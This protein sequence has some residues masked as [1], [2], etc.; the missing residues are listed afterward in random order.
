[1]RTL[2]FVCAASAALVLAAAGSSPRDI[3]LIFTGSAHWSAVSGKGGSSRQ[4]LASSETSAQMA[5]FRL[6]FA[7]RSDE[8]VQVDA[9]LRNLAA[10]DAWTG[11]YAV[12]EMRLASPQGGFEDI[13]LS[14]GYISS[15]QICMNS[16]RT[17]LKGARIWGTK[18]DAGGA[19]VA[20]SSNREFR[21]PNCSRWETRVSCGSGE[22]ANGV[23]A[24][25]D[26]DVG[27]TGSFHGLALRCQR[28]TVR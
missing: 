5:Y 25:Y 21:R 14:E 23:R 10:G 15:V 8:A 20:M 4:V 18:F 17:K 27:S 24:Y 9:Q 26:P 16:D 3:T 22:V 13:E 7:E 6:A 12:M 28:V 1:M 2:R 11:R 19:P